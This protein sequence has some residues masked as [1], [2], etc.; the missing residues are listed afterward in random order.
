MRT[1]NLHTI[2]TRPNAQRAVHHRECF[3]GIDGM[4]VRLAGPPR[5]GV[6]NC[7][8]TAIRMMM[9]ITT[10]A[11]IMI[12][13]IIIMKMRSCTVTACVTYTD[14]PTYDWIAR[15][16]NQRSAHCDWCSM[17]ALYTGEQQQPKRVIR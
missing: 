7:V 2:R 17:I 10:T 3:K 5:D 8:I 15:R 16:E 4:G 6:K 1:R 13:I 11:I 12:I 9:I 14:L